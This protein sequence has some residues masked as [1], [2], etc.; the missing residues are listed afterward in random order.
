M[1]SFVFSW[2]GTSS[3]R[4]S[5]WKWWT[6]SNQRSLAHRVLRRCPGPRTQ[7]SSRLRKPLSWTCQGKE[8]EGVHLQWTPEIDPSTGHVIWLFTMLGRLQ[9]TNEGMAACSCFSIFFAS[10]FCFSLFNHGE[11]KVI[12][13]Q[14]VAINLVLSQAFHG[15]P[16]KEKADVMFPNMEDPNMIIWLNVGIQRHSQHHSIVECDPKT[17]SKQSMTSVWRMFWPL[18]CLIRS[19]W[20]QGRKKDAGR[21]W[22]TKNGDCGPVE[23]GGGGENSKMRILWVKLG[24]VDGFPARSRHESSTCPWNSV[25][26]KIKERTK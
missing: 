9:R 22:S 23:I 7:I 19:T 25:V 20:V 3:W 14:R 26:A 15:L 11:H 2:R 4:H 10:I 24:S 6:P 1:H 13:H 12:R 8:N 17:G 16:G 18:I 21:I 5:G